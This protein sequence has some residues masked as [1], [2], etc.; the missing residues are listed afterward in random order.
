MKGPQAREPS[1]RGPVLDSASTAV[2]RVVEEGEGESEKDPC[3]VKSLS[4]VW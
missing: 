4:G 2:C 1:S 3:K